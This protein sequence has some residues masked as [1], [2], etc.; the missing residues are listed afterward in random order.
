M[1][2]ISPD[3]A[4]LTTRELNGRMSS[5]YTRGYDNGKRDSE[6]ATKG[7]PID[8]TMR[9]NFDFLETKKTP[10]PKYPELFCWGPQRV[11]IESVLPGIPLRTVFSAEQMLG[12]K[13]GA[14]IYVLTDSVPNIIWSQLTRDGWNVIMIDDSYARVKAKA[15]R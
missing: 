8:I 13:A 7:K 2:T 4:I 3:V 10:P 9:C 12:L 1:N 11:A 6:A 5:E 14:W 15:G